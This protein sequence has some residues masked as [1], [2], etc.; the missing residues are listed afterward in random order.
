MGRVPTLGVRDREPAHELRQ[1]AVA[2]RPEE[3]MPVIGQDMPCQNAHR[4]PLFGLCNH[5]LK[6]LE[7]AL[8][9]ENPHSPHGSIEHVICVSAAGNSQSSWHVR[10]TSFPL[11][12]QQRLPTPLFVPESVPAG[13]DRCRIER[14]PWWAAFA[15][16]LWIAEQNWCECR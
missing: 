14:V 9:A 12:Q 7:V 3:K 8:F 15:F 10:T 1:V 11:R 6:R 16:R 4:Q 13:C 5:L 2:T